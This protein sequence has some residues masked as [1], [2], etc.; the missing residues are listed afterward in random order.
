MFHII[1]GLL[2]KCYILVF[3][4]ILSFLKVILLDFVKIVLFIKCT[5][6]S[7]KF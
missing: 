5:S 3:Y 6:L 1:H 7:L 2:V 4:Y